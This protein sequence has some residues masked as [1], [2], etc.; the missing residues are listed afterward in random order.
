MARVSRRTNKIAPVQS[1]EAIKIWNTALY[2]RLSVMETRDRKDSESL[3]TQMELLSNYI[4]GKAQFH[5][6]GCYRDNG[7]TGTNFQRPD[8]MRMMED[9][10]VVR[11]MADLAVRHMHLVST[12]NN[13]EILVCRTSGFTIYV[14]P[15]LQCCSVRN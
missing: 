15:M 5:L 9:I 3:E 4:R 7:E 2:G 6:I 10:S 12:K 8:F 13:S 11:P 1:A 14:T